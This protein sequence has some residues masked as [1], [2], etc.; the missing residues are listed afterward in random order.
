MTPRACDTRSAG[1]TPAKAGAQVTCPQGEALSI[2]DEAVL[3]EALATARG[4]IGK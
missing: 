4:S 1:V 3:R 2:G